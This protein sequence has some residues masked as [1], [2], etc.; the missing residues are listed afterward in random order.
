MSDDQ[1]NDGLHPRHPGRG[2]AGVIRMES[3]DVEDG[4][5][6]IFLPSGATKVVSWRTTRPITPTLDAAKQYASEVVQ[7]LLEQ[8]GI[9]N[10]DIQRTNWVSITAAIQRV[11]LDF[12]DRVVGAI[13]RKMAQ[14]FLTPEQ[15]RWVQ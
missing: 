9:E 15:R 3:D 13:N 4:G 8:G 10:P 5:F 1:R 14:E 12:N 6:T 7:Q 11:I 2:R